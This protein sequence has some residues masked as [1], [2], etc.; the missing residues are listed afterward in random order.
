MCACATGEGAATK[1]ICCNICGVLHVECVPHT[2]VYTKKV[3]MQQRSIVATRWHSAI[4]FAIAIVVLNQLIHMHC[5]KQLICSYLRFI[6]N[7]T[8]IAVI[9][10]IANNNNNYGVCVFVFALLCIY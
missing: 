10:K 8:L 2:I 4:K 9:A 6:C 5:C 1:V 7:I 3:V